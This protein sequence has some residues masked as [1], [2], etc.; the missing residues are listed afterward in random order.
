[1]EVGLVSNLQY[2]K[3]I[4]I[5]Q[6]DRYIHMS[7]I[8]EEFWERHKPYTYM[9]VD[10]RKNSGFLLIICN[11]DYMAIVEDDKKNENAFFGD[12]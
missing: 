1:M 9:Y 3:A 6:D 12:S 5:S 2:T 4:E 8:G 7:H 10:I 11:Q